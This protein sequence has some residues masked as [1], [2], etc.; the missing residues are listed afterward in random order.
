MWWLYRILLFKIMPMCLKCMVFCLVK[1]NQYK[2]FMEVSRICSIPNSRT[3]YFYTIVAH[4]FCTS[5]FGDRIG[6]LIFDSPHTVSICNTHPV[7]LSQLLFQQNRKG[8]QNMLDAH[9]CNKIVNWWASTWHLQGGEICICGRISVPSTFVWGKSPGLYSASPSETYLPQLKT[10]LYLGWTARRETIHPPFLLH[11]FLV[12]IALNC[13]SE[14]PLN[15]QN[16]F[17][18]HNVMETTRK[19][20]ILL[21]TFTLANIICTWDCDIRHSYSNRYFE[22]LKLR[23]VYR[24]TIFCGFPSSR[25]YAF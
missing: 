17:P 5:L 7:V 18:R 2:S 23:L 4:F 20:T 1:K 19:W 16:A 22:E 8:Y 11:F 14:V 13:M 15:A 10:F 9:P 6:C 3:F 24:S 21:C 25:S 12:G